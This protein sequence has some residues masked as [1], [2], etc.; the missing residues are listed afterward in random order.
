MIKFM[1]KKLLYIL[2]SKEVRWLH[3]T[4]YRIL[5]E[6][7]PVTGKKKS[8]IEDYMH[9]FSADIAAF[10]GENIC[11]KIVILMF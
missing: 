3:Q 11:F 7:K 5:Q 2:T 1:T 8:I 4:Y 9:S 6:F 10:S